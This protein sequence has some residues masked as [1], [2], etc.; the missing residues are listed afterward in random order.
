MTKRNNRSKRKKSGKRKVNPLTVMNSRPKVNFHFDGQVLNGTG[1]SQ[2]L[3]TVAN[4]AVGIYYVDCSSVQAGG[5]GLWYQSI[6]KDFA[7]LTDYYSEYIFHSVQCDWLPYVSPGIADGGSQVYICYLDNA[8]E[9]ATLPGS[10]IATVFNIAKSSRNMKF[11]NAWERFSYHVPLS[12]RRKT[13]DTNYNTA[14]TVDVV[15]RSV[16]GVVVTGHVS[17]S[18]IVSLGQWRYTYTLELRNLNVNLT[19]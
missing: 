3:V 12:R 18:A 19:T 9:M 7:T 10:S 6:S 16:Q 14:Y 8:E 17:S 13:F 5:A 2:P 4:F 15:D 1:F 11:F